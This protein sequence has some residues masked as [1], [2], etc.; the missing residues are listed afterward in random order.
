MGVQPWTNTEREAMKNLTEIGNEILIETVCDSLSAYPNPTEMQIL[1][2]MLELAWEGSYSD[3]SAPASRAFE[4]ANDTSDEGYRRYRR[5]VE[6][7][8]ARRD[9]D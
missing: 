9:T 7:V 5:I 8:L 3:A 4:L 1:D 2:V 6:A